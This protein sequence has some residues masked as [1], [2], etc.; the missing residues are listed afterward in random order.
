MEIK[1]TVVI[2][3]DV[4]T[5]KNIDNNALLT[6]KKYSLPIKK[7]NSISMGLLSRLEQFGDEDDSEAR[8]KLHLIVRDL[9]AQDR[10][11]G[12]ADDFHNYVT[13]LVRRDEYDLA[14]DVLEVGIKAFPYNVDLIADYIKYGINCQRVD[15][16]RNLQK[17]LLKIPKK[18]W[19]WRGFSFYVDYLQY[20]LEQPFSEKTME[21][22][23]QEMVDIIKEYKKYYPYS[24]EPYITEAEIHKNASEPDLEEDVLKMALDTV[25]VAPKCSLRYADILFD[26]GRFDEAKPIIERAKKDSTKTQASVSDG[27]IYYLSALCTIALK[28]QSERE[29]TTEEVESIYND[30]NL[31]L[32]DFNRNQSFVK[33]IK[34]KTNMLVSKTNVHVDSEKYENLYNLI[35]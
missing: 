18:R 21:K 5:D 19:T 16:V 22:T 26:R 25:K 12:N 7:I 10:A 11:I 29:Y 31:A 32:K 6:T 23:E 8:E 13:E 1:E 14:C 15:R 34:S 35:D 4:T 27:Y 17:V 24:E 28:C 20:L 3:S 33:V 30:F 2:N 9:Q